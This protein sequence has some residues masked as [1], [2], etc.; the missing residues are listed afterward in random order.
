VEPL[1][2]YQAFLD[3]LDQGYAAGMGYM[4]APGYVEARSD[5]S[6]LLVGARSVV[7]VAL[8]YP[9]VIPSMPG[10]GSQREPI[11]GFVARYA[12]GRDY[13]E[14]LARKLRDLAETVSS[15]SGSPVQAR[16]CV[17]TAPLL[18]RDLAERACL[19]FVGKNSMLIIP[20]VGS[21]VLLGELLL[22]ADVEPTAPDRS[23]RARCGSCTACMDACPSAAFAAPYV[24]DARACISYL[25]IEHRGAIPAHLRPAVGVRIF[26]C[27]E[28][29]SACPYNTAAPD[30]TEPAPEFASLDPERAAPDLLDLLARGTNQR[31]RYAAGTALRRVNREQ[32]TRNLCVALGNA[33]DARA[34][35]ALVA[36]LEDRSAMIRGH[37]AWALGRLGATDACARALAREEHDF[38]RGE[39][40]CA[41]TS[42]RDS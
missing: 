21:Y 35:P 14:I 19:G 26:G 20:G 40:S 15:A 10:A 34:I 27:D 5:P 42:G 2:R 36:Q 31:K 9:K 23:G 30:R 4:A 39:L 1:A 28:C 8:A 25:T 18:E 41:L 6:S 24:L 16:A 38:V 29:Q 32:L 33:G 3:W 22:A 17:D 13:H 7:T 11:R 37:A 12:R